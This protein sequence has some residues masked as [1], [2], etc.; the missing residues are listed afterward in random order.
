MCLIFDSF[1]NN[2]NAEEFARDVKQKFQRRADVHST[3]IEMEG[4][5]KPWEEQADGKLHDVFPWILTPPIVLVER[6]PGWTDA[7]DEESVEAFVQQYGGEFA[8]T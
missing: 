5:G 7:S 2:A 1:K 6:L 4:E 3:Q 8:G